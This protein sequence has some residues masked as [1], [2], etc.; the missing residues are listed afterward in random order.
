MTIFQ[1]TVKAL[2]GDTTYDKKKRVLIIPCNDLSVAKLFEIIAGKNG[3]RKGKTVTIDV[4]N[5]KDV[6]QA[7]SLIEVV[8]KV[9]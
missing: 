9:K 2:F 8:V 4:G 3:T 1:K 5:M 7:L 6:E